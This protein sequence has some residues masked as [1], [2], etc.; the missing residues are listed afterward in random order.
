METADYLLF[1]VM[2]A[3]EQRLGIVCT[4]TGGWSYA[5]HVDRASWNLVRLVPTFTDWNQEKERINIAPEKDRAVEIEGA[6]SLAMMR[7]YPLLD[8]LF[9]VFPHPG[10]GKLTSLTEQPAGPTQAES[11]ALDCETFLDVNGRLIGKFKGK[12]GNRVL[13]IKQTWDKDL[14]FP[15][16]VTYSNSITNSR[17]TLVLCRAGKKVGLAFPAQSLAYRILGMDSQ[18]TDVPVSRCPQRDLIGEDAVAAVCAKLAPGKP[19]Q[20]LDVRGPA[21]FHRGDTIKIYWQV[22]AIPKAISGPKP[23]QAER[24]V[25]IP[26][27]GTFVIECADIRR[28]ADEDL[29][30]LLAFGDDTRSYSYDPM[31]GGGHGQQAMDIAEMMTGSGPSYFSNPDYW[32]DP[33]PKKAKWDRVGHLRG[34][35]YGR[36][37]FSTASSGRIATTWVLVLRREDLSLRAAY[38][39]HL[40]ANLRPGTFG[41]VVDS[42]KQGPAF[43][44]QSLQIVRPQ[45]W[46]L[47]QAFAGLHVGQTKGNVLNLSPQEEGFFRFELLKDEDAVTQLVKNDKFFTAFAELL[48]KRQ[49]P[50]EDRKG[51]KVRQAKVSLTEQDVAKLEGGFANGDYSGII[52]RLEDGAVKRDANVFRTTNGPGIWVY[53]GF[54][55]TYTWWKESLILN[56]KEGYLARLR[57]YVP[58]PPKPGS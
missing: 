33:D 54:D 25:E 34:A 5:L 10:Q 3:N 35:R 17:G 29:V 20:P 1:M 44:R 53:H 55:G 30:F 32:T 42:F 57:L 23:A 15:R 9:R 21:W 12:L 28:V 22:R 38:G 41:V 56:W 45:D 14:P 47:I 46:M 7:Q 2:E 19:S 40:D 48:A 11:G 36:Y 24:T 13:R 27:S 4:S 58:T 31:T 50:P 51:K 16:R 39:F 43:V 49:P 52:R 26:V 8:V 6:P 37:S 18:V